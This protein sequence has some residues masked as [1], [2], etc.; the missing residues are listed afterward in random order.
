MTVN[1]TTADDLCS[2]ER[3]SKQDI[4]ET[5]LPT[6]AE[7]LDTEEQELIEYYIFENFTLYNNIWIRAKRG[8]DN[9]FY[10]SE[11]RPIQFENWEPNHPTSQSEKSCVVL[12]SGYTR[13]D[14]PNQQNIDENKY[15]K[16]IFIYIVK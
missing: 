4:S 2:R 7:I 10:W 14:D 9:M 6:L 13:M 8:N 15:G 11:G 5:Y 3:Y 12:T 1:R 16:Y